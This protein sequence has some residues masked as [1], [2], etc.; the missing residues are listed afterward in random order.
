MGIQPNSADE[1]GTVHILCT[2]DVHLMYIVN[3]V[4]YMA[5]RWEI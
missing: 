4:I 2:F 5:I 1:N 3:V